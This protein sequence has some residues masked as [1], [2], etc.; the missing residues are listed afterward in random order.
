MFFDVAT[1]K[2]DSAYTTRRI[3]LL[4]STGLVLRTVREVKESAV[5]ESVHLFNRHLL[6][7]LCPGAVSGT[8]ATPVDKTENSVLTEL[9][10]NKWSET[11]TKTPHR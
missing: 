3:S 4:C 1:R 2:F 10:F 5:H 7:S 8:W 11:T 6:S 9:A